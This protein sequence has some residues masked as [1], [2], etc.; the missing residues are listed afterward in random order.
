MIVTIIL[1]LVGLEYVDASN[2]I[3]II[4]TVCDYGEDI[5]DG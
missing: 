3:D 2:I 5:A 1:Y 4:I